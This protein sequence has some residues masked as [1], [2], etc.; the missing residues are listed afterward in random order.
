M[1]DD[2]PDNTGHLTEVQY[3]LEDLVETIPAL[4]HLNNLGDIERISG[5]I[6][7]KLSGEGQIPLGMKPT[8]DQVKKYSA[9]AIYGFAEEIPELKSLGEAELEKLVEQDTEKIMKA[10]SMVKT[11]RAKVQ[12]IPKKLNKEN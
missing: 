2:K 3:I 11:V 4:A 12:F 6:A 1:Y 10:R 8:F 7:V 5:K 9:S